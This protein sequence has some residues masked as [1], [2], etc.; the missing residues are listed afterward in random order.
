MTDKRAQF[1]LLAAVLCFLL[2][3]VA[4]KDLR[5]LTGGIGVTYVLLAAASALDH[6]SRHR[7]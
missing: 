6:R 5:E 1:F 7:D 3:L 2:V 4:P